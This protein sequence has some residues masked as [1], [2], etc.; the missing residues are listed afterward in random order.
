MVRAALAT[1]AFLTAAAALTGCGRA[2]PAPSATGTT[3]GRV[4]TPAASKPPC[5]DAAL[6]GHTVAFTNSLGGTLTGYLLGEGNVGIVLANE[7]SHD[8]CTWL[9]YAKKLA[10]RYRLNFLVTTQ[11]LDLPVA[12]SSG[13]LVVYRL[14]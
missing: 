14:R 6:V 8:A 1:V 3:P 10:E 2:S 13:P 9:P 5:N 11:Q 12:Y 4:T 7:T